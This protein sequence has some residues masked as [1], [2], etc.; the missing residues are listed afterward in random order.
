MNKTDYG[1]LIQIRAGRREGGE[2]RPLITRM[3]SHESRRTSRTRRSA[4]S[5]PLLSLSF[6][7]SGSRP[8]SS[9]RSPHA[10]TPTHH[11]APPRLLLFPSVPGPAHAAEAVLSVSGSEMR[12]LVLLLHPVAVIVGCGDGSGGAAGG[13]GAQ[14]W[15]GRLR[16]AR[17]TSVGHPVPA[18]RGG[19]R[20]A[21]RGSHAGGLGRGR[22]SPRQVGALSHRQGAPKVSEVQSC[23]PGSLAFRPLR[24]HTFSHISPRPVPL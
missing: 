16:A 3:L 4:S 7:R 19:A 11:A 1:P 20:R 9:A 8:P 2:R 12:G 18:Y 21:S 23:A 10:R 17:S 6:I 13:E 24:I 15:D 22:A 14:L 5:S